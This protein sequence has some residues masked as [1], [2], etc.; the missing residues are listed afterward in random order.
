MPRIPRL[1]LPVLGAALVFLALA[2]APALA[3]DAS[4]YTQT[5]VEAMK[6]PDGKFVQDL[7]DRAI[8]VIANKKLSNAQRDAE[9][10]KILSDCFD[11]KTIGRFVIG[12]S[13]RAA[14]PAQQDEYM[15]LFKALVIKTYGTRM[16]LY[17]GE[18]FTVIGTRPESEMDTTVHSEITHPDG[19]APTQI[20]WRV[21][22]RDGKMGVIDVV[23]EGVSLS[24]T[25]RQEYAAII[26]NNGGRIEPLLQEM[27]HELDAQPSQT[28]ARHS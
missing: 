20:D 7:G 8:A 19:S 13:W 9:F 16:T 5:H 11:L 21:R 3:Q 27:R 28:A 24:V 12:R 22:N 1:S 10:S 23:V 18:G 25:Q 6:N 2:A 17:T 26:Q 4:G 14:T 15:K